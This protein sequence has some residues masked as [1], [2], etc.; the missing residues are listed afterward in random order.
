MTRIRNALSAYDARSMAV[1]LSTGGVLPLPGVWVLA[2]HIVRQGA[3]PVIVVVWVSI[4]SIFV[5]AAVRRRLTD[6]EFAILGMAGITGI[7]STAVVVADPRASEA[8]VLLCAV[9]PTIGAMSPV[10]ALTVQLAGFATAGSLLVIAALSDSPAGFMISAG[11]MIGLIIV[12]LFLVSALRRSLIRSLEQQTRIS[13]LDPLTGILNRRGLLAQVG[14]MLGGI[15]TT[16]GLVGLLL[17]DIDRFK[18]VNDIHGH[19]VG[20]RTLLQ[21]AEVLRRAAPP[22]A[23]ISRFGGEEF[24]IFCTLGRYE[25]LE[26][27]AEL[28]RAAVAESTPVTISVGAACVRVV[29]TREQTAL[30]TPELVDQLVGTADRCVY[31]A[32]ADGRNRTVTVVENPMWWRFTVT[33]SIP[34]GPT[35]AD[36]S[37]APLFRS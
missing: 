16:Q 29:P 20:D 24:L 1:L 22:G 11:C 2:P 25:D 4:T 31:Q 8:V 28:L 36:R 15:H 13:G 19:V 18:A 23:A 5:Y 17:I 35:V 26:A 37:T 9:I 3:W 14:E 34:A 27:A 7:L 6:T 30:S 33:E 32:K 10:R 12:P 21:T